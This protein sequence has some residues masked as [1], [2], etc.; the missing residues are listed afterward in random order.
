MARVNLGEIKEPHS[1]VPCPRCKGNKLERG[2][3]CFN[4]HGVN[5][6]ACLKCGFEIK[7]WPTKAKVTEG[8]P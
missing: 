3:Y 4:T 8:K 5:F 7:D 1:Y 6:V 2:Y